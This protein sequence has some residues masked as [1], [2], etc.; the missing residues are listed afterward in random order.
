MNQTAGDF[1][2]YEFGLPPPEVVGRINIHSGTAASV[3]GP[4]R[5]AFDARYPGVYILAA[6]Q[7]ADRRLTL[8]DRAQSR[9]FQVRAGDKL[10]YTPT[11][12]AKGPGSIDLSFSTPFSRLC[13]G[14]F[15]VEPH[16]PASESWMRR[17]LS[18]IASMTGLEVY[19]HPGYS[20]C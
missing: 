14:F 3:D 13:S 6:W 2:L 17:H 18:A 12:P 7:E 10:I 9:Q 4:L 5:A 16:S 19:L 20:D 15:Y 11:R 8:V 1:Q